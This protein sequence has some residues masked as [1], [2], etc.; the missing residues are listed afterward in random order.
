MCPAVLPHRDGREILGGS[1]LFVFPMATSSASG[2]VVPPA[3][4]KAELRV[5]REQTKRKRRTKSSG[6][7]LRL[8]RSRLV[9]LAEVL[10]SALKNNGQQQGLDLGASDQMSQKIKRWVVSLSCFLSVIACPG[11]EGVSLSAAVPSLPA[12]PPASQLESALECR[13]VM[14]RLKFPPQPLRSRVEPMP[15]SLSSSS[16]SSSF[17]SFSCRT[18]GCVTFEPWTQRRRTK[19][20]VGAA[21]LQEQKEARTEGRETGGLPRPSTPGLHPKG[22]EGAEG[23]VMTL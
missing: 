12:R 19:P 13:S 2:I 15:D 23:D 18:L 3:S 1:P 11:G 17:F 6:T 8:R 16:T 10:V 5:S 22:S 20:G 21:K 14:R 4:W 9:S 7:L